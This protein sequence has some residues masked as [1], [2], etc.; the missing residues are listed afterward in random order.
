[1]PIE[2]LPAQRDA[3][4]LRQIREHTHVC[5]AALPRS[6]CLLTMYSLLFIAVTPSSLSTN[7]G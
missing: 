7:G 6:F 3:T 1:M 2:R 5:D 4:L